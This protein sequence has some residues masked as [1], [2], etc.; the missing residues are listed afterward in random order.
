MKHIF[1][2]IF[3]RVALLSI[4]SLGVGDSRCCRGRS[5]TWLLRLRRDGLLQ[6]GDSELQFA[7]QSLVLG[8]QASVTCL[9]QLQGARHPLHLLLHLLWVRALCCHLQDRRVR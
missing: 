6:P 8:Q 9:Q 7:V 4:S 1:L 5:F 3:W 2:S